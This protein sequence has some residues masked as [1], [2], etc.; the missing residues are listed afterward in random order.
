MLRREAA[1][2]SIPAA[3]DPSTGA[4]KLLQ[5]HEMLLNQP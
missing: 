3:G 1:T 5:N 2:Y 4:V